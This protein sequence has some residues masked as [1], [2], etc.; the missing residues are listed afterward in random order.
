MIRSSGNALAVSLWPSS[1]NRVVRDVLL[2]IAGSVLLAISAKVKVW[3]EPV[4]ITLQTFTVMVLAAA[5][6]SRLAMLTVLAYLA[7]GFAGIPVFTNTP[8]VL[9]GPAYFLGPTAGFLIGFL[10]LAWIVGKAADL[11]WD[12][13]IP[14][15]GAAMIAADAVVFA[16]GFCWLAWFLPRSNGAV[17]IG[18]AAAYANGIAPFVLADLIKIALAACAVPAVWR[19]VGTRR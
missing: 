2:I 4:P 12:K 13:S 3:Q 14:K 1:V 7:E 17:G 15:L 11:G 8:P 16:M 18:M 6:G 9:A 19:L 5:Y 10:P